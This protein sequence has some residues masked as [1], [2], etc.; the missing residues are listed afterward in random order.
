VNNYKTAQEDELMHRAKKTGYC[1]L[2]PLVILLLSTPVQADIKSKVE[3]WFNN[4][5]YANV[6]EPGVYEGQSA[7]YFTAGGLTLK[8]PITQTLH[9]VDVQM[10]RYNA[11]CAGIDLFTGGFSAINADQFVQNL[12]A[13]GQNAQSLA[14]M[15]AI[16]VVSPQLKAVM[17]EVQGW[18]NKINSMN[19]DSCEAATKL[20]GGAMN[21]AGQRKSNCIIRRMQDDGEDWTTA[22]HSCTT[23]DKIVATEAKGDSANEVA[24]VKGNLTWMVLMQD[25][26]FQQD[27]L[28]AELVMNLTGTLII[29]SDAHGEQEITSI[30]PALT[31]EHQRERF[32]N[33]YQS[34]LLGKDSQNPL[35]LHRCQGGAG[36]QDN[37]C[38]A[39]TRV[40]E[41]T[42]DWDGLYQRINT[43]VKGILEKIHTDKP[44]TQEEKGLIAS[45]SIP[46][47]RYLAATASAFPQQLDQSR[48][49]HDYTAL[50]ASDILLLALNG[51]L[52]RVEHN[53]LNLQGGMADTKRVT[54][55]LEQLD[56]VMR[57]VA[58]L[59]RK[60]AV[61]GQEMYQ[62]QLEIRAYEQQLIAALG[63]RYVSNLM[64]KP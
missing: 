5:N 39:I 50:I 58:Q 42:G 31:G 48:L 46:L 38:H 54:H 57:G 29:A 34:L 32:T 52:E 45:T 16:G 40:Q 12:R 44:L 27:T 2:V 37:G 36:S 20:V 23:D 14:F 6:T 63:S 41:I 60:Q 61:T 33:I 7:R 47:Y 26:F 35:Q 59:Q 19:M 25:P 18:A 56:L 8:A 30:A 1:S 49:T 15:L 3:N 17:E 53:A 64:F 43:L 51:I 55:Y 10:P 28:F 11:G 24:F 13:I 21:L 62:M 22:S 9:F 4:M